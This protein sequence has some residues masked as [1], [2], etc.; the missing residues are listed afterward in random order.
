[1]KKCDP[2]SSC[3]YHETNE[4][5]HADKTRI[6]SS[7]VKCFA[8]GPSIFKHRFIDDNPVYSK[9]FA[10]GT[11]VHCMVLEPNAVRERY[12]V[13]PHRDRRTKAY[14]EWA[15]EHKDDQRE[16]VS[17]SD[18]DTANRCADSVY[19]NEFAEALFTAHGTTEASYRFKH[20]G[21]ACKFRPDKLIPQTRAVIDLKTIQ[22]CTMIDIY[23]SV[24]KYRYG[25]QAAHYTVGAKHCLGGIEDFEFYFVF[26]ETAAPYRCCT[27][28]CTRRS[29][30]EKIEQW[31]SILIDLYSRMVADDWT[32]TS[33]YTQL[34]D[35]E[36]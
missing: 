11:L 13:S 6:S 10:L 29:L 3:L 25:L 14:K 5:Y 15:S 16:I 22:Q 4:Q 9:S 28:R 34:Q 24:Q 30:D 12:L 33:T 23:K 7:M 21:I 35:L 27:L 32:E 8:S 20:S 36:V 1:M 17:Q 19:D 18:W 2:H 31:E 26:V